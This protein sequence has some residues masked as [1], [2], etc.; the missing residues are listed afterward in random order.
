MSVER[1]IYEIKTIHGTA[2]L[3]NKTVDREGIPVLFVHGFGSSP[4]NWFKFPD[5]LG[6]F[7]LQKEEIDVWSLGLSNAVSGDITVLTQEDLYSSLNS[8]YTVKHAPL[9]KKTSSRIFIVD[10]DY[11]RYSFLDQTILTTKNYHHL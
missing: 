11:S 4:E 7:F 2:R 9:K 3:I 10:I 5:S 6:K 1:A 8:I